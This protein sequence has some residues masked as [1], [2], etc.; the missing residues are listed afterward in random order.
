MDKKTILEKAHP[1]IVSSIN[2]YALSKDEFEDL[3]QEGVI[4]ILES[5]E[6]YD[7]SRGVDLFCYLKMQLKYYYLNYGRYNK[8]TI[9]IYEPVGEGIDIADTLV[10]ESSS[11]EDIL[12]SSFELKEAYNSLMDLSY[13]DRYIV[14]ESIIRQRTLDDLAKELGINR[15]TLFR[16][17]KDIVKRLSDKLKD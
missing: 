17:K 3:Y 7:E 11:I 12:L 15:T 8:K 4:V 14:E 2:K 16:K 1:L 9:S 13:E 6:K 5:I 10:D